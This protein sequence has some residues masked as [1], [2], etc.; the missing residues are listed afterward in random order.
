VLDAAGLVL[1][2]GIT[3]DHVNGLVHAETLKRGAYP[4]PL[5]YCGKKHAP[6]SAAA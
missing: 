3:T 5:N 2:P 4:S 1:V 6:T